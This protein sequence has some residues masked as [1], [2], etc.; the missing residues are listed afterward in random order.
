MRAIF[1]GKV[2]KLITGRLER[3]DKLPDA[4][5]EIC[6]Q[7]G[8]KSGWIFAIGAVSRISVMTYEQ[9]KKA[10]SEPIEA[11]GDYE[12]LSLT[13]NVSLVDDKEFLHLHVVAAELVEGKTEVIVGHL[14]SAKV[15]AL[16]FVLLP[17]G[18]VGLKRALDEQTGLKLW[19]K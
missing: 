9:R 14:V 16:E 18:D 4:L 13:G 11:E 15:F 6:K 17:I 3:D 19:Q 5:L 1:E 8:V 2:K 10:Y 12:I 7:H